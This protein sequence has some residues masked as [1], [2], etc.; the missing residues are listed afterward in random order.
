[1]LSIQLDLASVVAV[2][3]K[4]EELSCLLVARSL[5]ILSRKIQSKQFVD[6]GHEANLVSGL[7]SVLK[8]VS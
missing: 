8:S 5:P 2:Q 1:M 4:D 7:S 3:S 6:L